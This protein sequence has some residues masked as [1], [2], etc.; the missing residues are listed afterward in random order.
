M[1]IAVV[2]S[3]GTFNAASSTTIAASA[4]TVVSGNLVVVIVR[5]GNTQHTVSGIADT[6]GNTYT[7]IRTQTAAASRLDM[8]YS[9]NVTGNASN[10]VTATYSAAADNRAILVAQ[11]SGVSTTAPVLLDEVGYPD[12]TLPGSMNIRNAVL[13]MATQVDA[14]GSTWTAG[15]GFT[16]LV[17]DASHVTYLEQAIIGASYTRLIPSASTTSGAS[18]KMLIA[19]VFTAQVGNGGSGGG[20]W[21]FA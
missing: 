21:A 3:T 13:L 11:L 6:A 15:S 17:Q 7:Q 9:A 18:G 10:V 2:N 14:V 1:S 19:A 12:V 5:S 20:A 8:W 4:L 16:T